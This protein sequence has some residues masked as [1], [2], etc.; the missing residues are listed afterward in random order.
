MTR[1]VNIVTNASQTVEDG[2]LQAVAA[3]ENGNRA[4]QGFKTC[5]TTKIGSLPTYQIR[6]RNDLIFVSHSPSGVLG[7]A[8]RVRSAERT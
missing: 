1:L 8:C 4:T 7:W 3:P 6:N 5:G 2:D